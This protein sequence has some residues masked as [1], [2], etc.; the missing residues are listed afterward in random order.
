[1]ERRTVECFYINLD[2]AAQRREYLEN[3]FNAVKSPHWRLSRYPARDAAFVAAH[4]L[5]GRLRPAEKACFASHRDLIHQ[6]MQF[7]G[8]VM[9]LEDDAQFGQKTCA[10]IDQQ[11]IA[12]PMLTGWDIIY[13]DVCI[14]NIEDMVQLIRGR[15]QL[16]PE[17]LNFFDLRAV[18]YA[19]ATAYIVN[20]HSKRKVH[21]LLSQM[22]SLDVPYDL[23]LKKLVMEG[24]I[25]ALAAFP[26]VTTLS[27]YSESSQI[28]QGGHQATETVLNLFRKMIWRERDIA[29]HR[30]L[31]EALD[32]DFCDDESRAFAVLWAVMAN[33]NF[34]I[35]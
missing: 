22:P 13:T 15:Q 1:M 8:H 26:F 12:N 18:P 21:D 7:E 32:R 28:Q 19:G 23:Y 5:P 30:A 6:S 34:T 14:P 25:T 11:I 10:A 27:D 24:K 3:N 16:E 20:Q 33:R 4:N 2:S 35:K 9:I 31:L 17:R 29:R